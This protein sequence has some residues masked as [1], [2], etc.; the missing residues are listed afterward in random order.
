[1]AT[2]FLRLY[3]ELCRE[4][5]ESIDSGIKI[6]SSED[7]IS[8]VQMY[9]STRLSVFNQL[10]YNVGDIN[11]K[12]IQPLKYH[13]KMARRLAEIKLTNNKSSNQIEKANSESTR[14]KAIKK[15]QLNDIFIE[16]ERINKI[17]SEIQKLTTEG[18]SIGN[19]LVLKLANDSK[20]RT[21]AVKLK[22]LPPISYTQK[23]EIF[24]SVNTSSNKWTIEEREKL[25]QLYH[26]IEKPTTNYLESWNLYYKNIADRFVGLYPK[27][28][29]SDVVEKIII[30][31]TS[32]QMKEKGEIEYWKQKNIRAK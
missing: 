16:T 18:K 15:K 7:D 22:K 29:H 6:K 4:T 25:N 24:I 2:E 10:G 21:A 12:R 26:E 31:I 27:R 11:P 30:M 28:K 9:P 20:S 32:R 3:K 17:A 23:R 5:K 19:D 14:E 1:M 13:G 8:H